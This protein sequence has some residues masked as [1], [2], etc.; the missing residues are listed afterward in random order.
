[1]EVIKCTCKIY[2]NMTTIAQSKKKE[3][4]KCTVA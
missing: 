2:D 4:W 1:M 3:K